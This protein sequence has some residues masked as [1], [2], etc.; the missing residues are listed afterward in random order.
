[1]AL[2]VYVRDFSGITYGPGN[3]SENGSHGRPFW[4]VRRAIVY[5]SY[6]HAIR[7][8]MYV[9]IGERHAMNGAEDSL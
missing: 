2:G 7:A 8:Y 6:T 1:M 9:C 5:V 3:H 4:G